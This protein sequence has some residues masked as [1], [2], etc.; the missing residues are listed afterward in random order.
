AFEGLTLIPVQSKL[1]RPEAFPVRYAQPDEVTVQ[2]NFTLGR[3]HY[4][5][6]Q[7]RGS[8]S[9][10]SGFAGTYGAVVLFACIPGIPRCRRIGVPAVLSSREGCWGK[11][12][13]AADCPSRISSRDRDVEL[14]RSLHRA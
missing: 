11:P 13:H 12:D 9:K 1:S 4:E 8:C 3:D 5:F 6:V 7:R 2:P 10:P 14:D